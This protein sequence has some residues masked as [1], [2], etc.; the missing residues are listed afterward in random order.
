MV[1]IFLSELYFIIIIIIWSSQI[2]QHGARSFGSASIV[3]SLY[4]DS[5][6]YF[7]IPTAGHRRCGV[8]KL[9]KHTCIDDARCTTTTLF[10]VNCIAVIVT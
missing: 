8:L 2:P 4:I 7:M 6:P 9:W 5:T 1:F 3:A 10:F